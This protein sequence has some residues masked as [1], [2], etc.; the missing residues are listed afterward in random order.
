M[1]NP[2]NKEGPVIR[3]RLAK[4][5]C[6]WKTLYKTF[7]NIVLGEVHDTGGG[8]HA[9]LDPDGERDE[10]RGSRNLQGQKG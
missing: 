8:L 9:P 6:A 7:F 4:P 2:D 3:N 10:Q 5:H 1:V